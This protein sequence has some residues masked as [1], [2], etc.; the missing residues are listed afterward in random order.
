MASLLTIVS[1]KLRRQY[2]ILTLGPVLL[3]TVLSLLSVHYIVWPIGANSIFA[4]LVV[5]YLPYSVK[6]LVLDDLSVNPEHCAHSWSFT[7]CYRVWNNPQGL[8]VRLSPFIKSAPS[9]SSARAIFAAK[10]IMKV[11]AL[12]TF[13][14]LIFQKMLAHV[15]SH[16]S[17]RDFAPEM[18][19][20]TWRRGLHMPVSQLVVRATISIQWIWTAY[21]LMEVGHTTLG[22]FFVSIGYDEPEEWTQ[23][24]GSL[25]NATSVRGFWGK[26]WHRITVP[27]YAFYSQI[28]CRQGLGIDAG[29][30]IEKTIVPMLIFTISG[31]M[32]S[33]VGWSLGDAALSRDLLFFFVNFLA[34]ALETIIFKTAS[35][36]A[37][38]DRVPGALRTIIG[39]CWV[40]TF[41]FHVAPLW[42]Y[43]KIHYAF[44]KAGIRE[45]L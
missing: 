2:R 32:H 23:L 11:A 33:L 25:R 24:Y 42:M 22:A 18:E 43:P 26:F 29:S 6:L 15:F 14:S 28:I 38:R 3:L 30:G 41:F 34:A 27:T 12:W 36:K 8:Q 5:F 9:S 13:D 39:F 4:S 31:L 10:S 19:L 37:S 44:I 45:T 40:F 35:F 1:L 7:D 16:V 17:P 21:V 20:F